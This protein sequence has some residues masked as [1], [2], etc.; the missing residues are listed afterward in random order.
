M[1]SSDSLLT[2]VSSDVSQRTGTVTRPVIS[3][4]RPAGTPRG[5]SHSRGY[6]PRCT[7]LLGRELPAVVVAVGVDDV[8]ADSIL[9]P[10]QRARNN[11]RPVGPRAR[12]GDVEVVPAGLWLEAG[13]RVVL[14]EIAERRRPA[15]ELTILVSVLSGVCAPLAVDEHVHVT[16]QGLGREKVGSNVHFTSIETPRLATRNP[17]EMMISR[18]PR[19]RRTSP[20]AS[21]IGCLDRRRWPRPRTRWSRGRWA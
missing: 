17:K 6:C 20:S 13:V 15:F 7:L 14:D 12:V 16:R 4:G 19:P 21:P 18:F 10:L 1:I 3:G 8:D 5:D 11:E 9:Q 2:M